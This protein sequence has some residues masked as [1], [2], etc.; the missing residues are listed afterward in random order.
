MK[1]FISKGWETSEKKAQIIRGQGTLELK[2]T[3]T[4]NSNEIWSTIGFMLLGEGH[5]IPCLIISE[6]L[7]FC[8]SVHELLLMDITTVLQQE[9]DWFFLKNSWL[10]LKKKPPCTYLILSPQQCN[11]WEKNSSTIARFL[12]SPPSE[13]IPSFISFISVRS[14]VVHKKFHS[15]NSNRGGGGGKE[16]LLKPILQNLNMGVDRMTW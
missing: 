9:E 15:L 11:W 14:F 6:T 8:G 16:Y 10:F 7:I 5:T 4:V 2:A 12:C 1:L 3:G 13:S